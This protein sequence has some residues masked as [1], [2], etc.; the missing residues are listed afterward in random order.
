MPPP[1]GT[2]STRGPKT[3]KPPGTKPPTKPKGKPKTVPRRVTG[4]RPVERS[5]VAN[6]SE[7]LDP[8]EEEQQD[9]EA[10]D[11]Q[12]DDEEQ[13]EGDQEEEGAEEQQDD[14]PEP[15]RVARDAYDEQHQDDEG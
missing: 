6:E 10:P 2:S 5:R 11:G 12:Q 14:S 4:K 15:Q 7:G 9:E 13:D 8:I 1:R 3:T